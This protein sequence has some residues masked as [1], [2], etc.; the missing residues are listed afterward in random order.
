MDCGIVLGPYHVIG[1]VHD[2]GGKGDVCRAAAVVLNVREDPYRGGRS[3]CR[4]RRGGHVGSPFVKNGIHVHRYMDI[5]GNMHPYRP[6]YSAVGLTKAEPEGK[7]RGLH[8]LLR[9]C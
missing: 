9:S 6:E 5:I 8:R 7:Y 3:V 4:D 1:R 2:L